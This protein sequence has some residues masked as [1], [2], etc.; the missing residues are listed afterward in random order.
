[1]RRQRLTTHSMHSRLASKRRNPI[2]AVAVEFAL[3][4]PLFFII[5]LTM[6]EFSRLKVIRHTMDNAAYEA[7]R[8]GIVPGA[9]ADE[10]LAEARRLL[11]IVG[12]R[13]AAV[14]INPAI[15]GPDVQQVTISIQT[16]L[17]QNALVTPKFTGGQMLTST[18]T[19]KTERVSRP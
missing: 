10:A 4:A 18:A 14:N 8:V 16:P 9:T 15:L 19:L 6:F 17:D 1:M 7:A 12:T 5:V 2:G 11:A 13:G 3:V